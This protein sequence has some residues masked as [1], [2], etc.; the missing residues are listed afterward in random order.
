[1]GRLNRAEIIGNLGRDPDVR[2]L[3]DGT[4]VASFRAATTEKWKDAGG[5]Q[6]EATEWHTVSIFGPLAEIAE[7]YLRKG[8]KVYVA[9]KLK[10][11]K[12]TD[13]SGAERYSTEIVL[14]GPTAVLELLGDP[15]GAPGRGDGGGQG[16][17]PSAAPSQIE[18]D[19]I[20]F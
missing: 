12:W 13:Q 20:P 1:M 4:R 8:S 3:P 9:G 18:D 10:T 6:R 7:R 5:A 15:S 11:R 19:E 16:G 2:S 17:Y 14:S